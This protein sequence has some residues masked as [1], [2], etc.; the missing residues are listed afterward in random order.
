MLRKALTLLLFFQLAGLVVSCC[1]DEIR[2][3]WIDLSLSLLDNSALIPVITEADSVPMKAFGIRVD[4]EDTIWYASSL[5]SIYSTAYATSCDEVYVGS[6][7][8]IDI[9]IKTIGAFSS[10]VPAASD[11]SEFFLFRLPGEPHADYFSLENVIG[12]I[13]LSGAVDLYLMKPPVER[14]LYQFQVEVLLSDGIT[15]SSTSREVLL[16]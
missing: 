11:I 2:Y 4:L 7:S 12:K 1:E 10:N 13:T 9:R 6:H 16:Y 14:G 8:I 3:K 5:P 15:H